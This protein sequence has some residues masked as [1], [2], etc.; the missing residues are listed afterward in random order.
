MDGG[1]YAYC[2]AMREAQPQSLFLAMTL[3][4]DAAV[5]IPKDH[6]SCPAMNE[7]LH[8]E[9]LSALVEQALD[10]NYDFLA[11]LS[12]S[13]MQ[14]ITLPFWIF[15]AHIHWRSWC[16]AVFAYL[17]PSGWRFLVFHTEDYTHR[18]GD[19]V[20]SDDEQV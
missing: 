4:T 6:A 13:T 18:K 11:N 8:E 17:V 14:S 12:D 20:L 5:Y 2:M 9:K 1:E 3:Y 19:G 16:F 7:L 15:A 10:M